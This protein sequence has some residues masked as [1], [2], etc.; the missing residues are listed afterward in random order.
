MQEEMKK[1]EEEA[2]EEEKEESGEGKEEKAE[3][4]AQEQEKAEEAEEELEKSELTEERPAGES[5][6]SVY[7]KKFAL[8]AVPSLISI[9]FFIADS[10]IWGLIFV[11]ISFILILMHENFTP[12]TILY[13]FVG[14]YYAFWEQEF[15]FA[16]SF[17]VIYLLCRII[18]FVRYDF[19]RS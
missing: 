6:Y 11:A 3:E 19:V 8:G 7:L 10:L 9:L 18:K 14:I 2:R 5:K 12:G 13:L 1:R 4:K 17:V 15:L 16:L